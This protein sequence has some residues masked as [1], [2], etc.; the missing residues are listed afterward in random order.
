MARIHCIG[1]PE[2]ES[3]AAAIKYLAESLPP[4]YRIIHNFE[5]CARPGELPYEYDVCVLGRNAVYHVEVKHFTGV[6]RGDKH[7]WRFDSGHT[8]PSPIP[9]ANKKS[10]ILASRLRKRANL[11]RVYVDTVVLITDPRAGI[12][13]M[14]DQADRVIKI[15]TDYAIRR[16][17]DPTKLPHGCRN[18]CITS[19]HDEIS[20]AIVGSNPA[21]S[22]KL[23]QIGLY[24]IEEK[25]SQYD[26]HSVF[27]A[28]HRYLTTRPRT[29]LKVY[30]YDLYAAP[31][32][33]ERQLQAIFHDQEALRLIS[34]HP[35]II[36]TG[37]FFASDVNS[38]DFVLPHEYFER[39]RTLEDILDDSESAKLTWQ[40]KR[41]IIESVAKG[42][43]HCHKANIIHRDLKPHSIVVVPPGDGFGSASGIS[44]RNFKSDGRDDDEAGEENEVLRVLLVNFDLA[45]IRSGTSATILKDAKDRLD[46]R[47]TAPEVW[48]D[49]LCASEASDV[50]SLGVT[51]HELI[52]GKRPFE[53]IDE[54]ITKK[55][56]QL[57]AERLVAELSA[58][59]RR[60]FYGKPE[61]IVRTIEQMLEIDPRCRHQSMDD[62][63]KELNLL[64]RD[65]LRR[66][67]RITS[68]RHLMQ[69]CD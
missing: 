3:E 38:A 57:D 44:T 58:P 32:E 65:G 34:S 63:I 22:R 18:N 50:F 48:R 47:Y 10:K 42:L 62:V 68:M 14:D 36:R 19:L 1:K 51:F 9:L 30:H 28:S 37:D 13:I 46:P 52:T 67:E 27:L 17:T 66:S 40:D 69:I 29:I 61:N 55:T 5:A 4:D 21:P 39:G 24:N 31:K 2:T 11:G 20:D 59:D 6:I 12:R 25:I 60:S 33:R 7:R 56:A 49:P 45:R 41:L 8:F 16:L 15:G 26:S 54:V 43:N 35:S 53:H 23:K 64:E